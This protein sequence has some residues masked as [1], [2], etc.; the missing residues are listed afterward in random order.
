MA[1]RLICQTQERR[2]LDEGRL[3]M[4]SNPTSNAII[5]ADINGTKHLCPAEPLTII[6]GT[7]SSFP[8]KIVTQGSIQDVQPIKTK[9]GGL[10]RHKKSKYF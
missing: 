8:R 7:I 5:M 10:T 1:E 4:I 6:G 9:T 3:E 2:M